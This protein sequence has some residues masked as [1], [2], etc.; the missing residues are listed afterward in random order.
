MTAQRQQCGVQVGEKGAVGWCTT[1]NR[2]KAG[3]ED[4]QLDFPKWA[5]S[6]RLS[7]PAATCRFYGTKVFLHVALARYATQIYT[8]DPVGGRSLLFALNA[9]LVIILDASQCISI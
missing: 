4:S 5:W 3:R 7:L 1:S 9:A 2:V 8:L 6:V